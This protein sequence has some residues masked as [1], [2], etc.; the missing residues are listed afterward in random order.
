MS[1]KHFLLLQG[2]ATPFFSELGK[3]IKNNGH[4]VTKINFCGGDRLFCHGVA[5]V[6]YTGKLDELAAW[7]E[8][9]VLENKI[10]DAVLFGDS[11][12][13]HQALLPSLRLA[14]INIYV[15]EEGYFRPHWVTLEKDGVNGYSPHMNTPASKWQSQST[16]TPPLADPIKM[17][18]NFKYR[19]FYDFIYRLANG[20]MFYKYREYQ[21]HRPLNGVLEYLGW[22]KRFSINTLWRKRQD[23]LNLDQFMEQGLPFYLLPLQLESDAQIHTHSP[24]VKIADVIRHVIESFAQDAPTD[25]ILVIKNHPLSTGIPNH[26]KTIQT[27]A[28]RCSVAHRIL[29]IETGDLAPLLKR[30]RGTVLVNSTTATQAMFQHSP[31]IALGKALFNLEGLTHQGGLESF[32]T[33]STPPN[34][35]L[36]DAYR[37]VLMHE[38]Q[39]NGDFYSPKGIQRAVQ[40]SLQKLNALPENAK[41][42][43]QKTIVIT[44]ASKG[45]GAALAIGYAQTNV[46]LGLIARNTTELKKIANTCRQ[47]GAEVI[48]AKVDVSEQHA[49]IA[50]LQEFD[51]HH[52]I[53]LLITNAGVTL[54]AN[55]DGS[56]ESI[57][58]AANLI[59]IN[60][61]G[62]LNSVTAVAERMRQRGKGQIALVSSL[63]AYFGMPVTPVYCAS[64]AAI[65]SYGEALRGLLAPQGVQVNIICPGFVETDLSNRFP[66]QRPFLITPEEAADHI[67]KGLA[68]N[69]TIIA[70]PKLLALGMK[71]IQLLPFPIASFFMGLSGYNR[72]EKATK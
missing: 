2:V 43:Y 3:A 26:H 7:I 20:V 42:R 12:P 57:Q 34:S 19:A 52:P 16:H 66:G 50:W 10:S 27:T 59:N 63:A 56:L 41:D 29:Y 40:G 69:R 58:S 11:R 36:L 48:T 71:A 60:L 72:A 17:G 18:N 21:N 70:F 14:K 53:D 24:F 8:A 45:I 31:V 35:K 68:K 54:A 62:T 6:N 32:W 47:Q 22:A 61:M 38:T 25:S 39:I 49:L 64:K 51:Q 4:Q 33:K 46:R 28:A 1:S 55:E 30:T 65:K 23:Q 15:F 5:S 44:G 67:I 9:F 13:I 37:H